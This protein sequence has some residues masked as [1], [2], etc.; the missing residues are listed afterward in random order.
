VGE[1]TVGQGLSECRGQPVRMV[2]IVLSKEEELTRAPNGE[3]EFLRALI[4]FVRSA[5]LSPDREV[6]HAAKV[7]ESTIE[8]RVR[9]TFQERRRRVRRMGL[10]GRMGPMITSCQSVSRSQ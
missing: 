8:F 2:E 3:T 7:W 4:R 9:L 6:A 5:K 10:I 1:N